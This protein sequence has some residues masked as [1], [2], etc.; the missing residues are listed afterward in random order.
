MPLLDVSQAAQRCAVSVSFLNKLRTKGGGPPYRV[1]GRC[2]RYLDNEIDDWINE[3]KCR[4]TS[5]RPDPARPARR[6]PA[7]N[8]TKLLD[9][10]L[11]RRS[12][13]ISAGKKRTKT[14]PE[15]TQYS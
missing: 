7:T 4:N 11:N 15:A 8:K 5:E 1:L 2:I 9:K 6:L 12:G 13:A 10:A 14:A 3:H